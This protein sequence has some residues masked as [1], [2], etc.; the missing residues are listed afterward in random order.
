MRLGRRSAALLA[1]FA[2][3]PGTA[4]AAG[5]T[6][7]TSGHNGAKANL[8]LARAPDGTLHALWAGP[9]ARPYTAAFDTAISPRGALATPQPVLSG[10]FAVAPPAAVA[11]A[12][13]SIHAL[14]SGQRT[15][16]LDDPN[17]GLNVASGPGGWVLGGRAFG[18]SPITDASNSDVGVVARA[19]GVLVSV[20]QSAASLLF[21]TGID[22][23]T[24]PQDITPPGDPA[25]GPVIAA[26]PASGEIVIAYHVAGS[27]GSFFRRI[28]PELGEPAPIPGGSQDAPA[29][30]ARSTGGVYTAYTPDGARVLL[31]RLGGQ[32]AQVPVPVGAR[33]LTA[34]VA[35]GPEGRMWV[36]YGDERTTRVTRSNRAVTA[37]EPVQSFNSPPG[38]VQYFRLEG[39]GSA[40]PLD[41]FADVTVDGV[42]RD[43]S[44]HRHVRPR[45]SLRVTQRRVAGGRVRITTRVT[46]A[47]DAV[48]GAR[49]TGLPGGTRTTNAAGKAV[50]TVDAERSGTLRLAARAPG[51]AA[52]HKRLAL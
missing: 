35:G 30:A 50:R 48:A 6:Q 15:G 7:L 26:D 36:F 10:W 9:A 8:G 18:R 13:G 49:V 38:T 43:G 46:D 4:Q 51:Y 39:E 17:A 5:W 34:G 3:L 1:V 29:I 21:Q 19:D 12:D 47:G 31:L 27:G 42:A 22:P 32:P 2:A 14:V 28:V 40:G 23:A 20:W 45:L 41:L 37:F 24:A 33:V 11:T 25:T 52:A 44:Y 16:T